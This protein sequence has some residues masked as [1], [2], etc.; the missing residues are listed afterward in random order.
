MFSFLG[1][2]MFSV[3][4]NQEVTLRTRTFSQLRPQ[5]EI[6]SHLEPNVVSICQVSSFQIENMNA[7]SPIEDMV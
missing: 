3:L 5:L 2:V 4:F 1:V 7:F 6:E